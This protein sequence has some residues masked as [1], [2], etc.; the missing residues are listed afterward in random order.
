MGVSPL[1]AWRAVGW[2]GA[3][4]S[5]EAVAG[6]CRSPE[7]PADLPGTLPLLVTHVLL[8]LGRA[9]A[10]PG[11]QLGEEQ[12]SSAELLSICPS[13][14]LCQLSA[15]TETQATVH[16]GLVPGGDGGR[17]PRLPSLAYFIQLFVIYLAW[18]FLD[19]LS[20]SLGWPWTPDPSVS[21]FCA[22][23]NRFAMPH[24][25]LQSSNTGE[26]KSLSEGTEICLEM[27]AWPLPLPELKKK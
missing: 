10:A 12:G 11:A 15:G 5:W 6:C 19:S 7:T 17:S 18:L 1:A 26:I 8:L 3:G 23:V 27:A 21:A 2:S 13:A 25:S 24:L 16:G 9:Q 22:G 20:C 14:P 4:T